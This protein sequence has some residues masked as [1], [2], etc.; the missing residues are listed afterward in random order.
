MLQDDMARTGRWLFRWRSY[1]PMAMLPLAAWDIWDLG[2]P[3]LCGWPRLVHE[4]SCVAV[5]LAGLAIRALTVGYA[6]T[7]TSERATGVVRAK[8]LNT[9]GPYSVVRNPLYLGNLLLFIGSILIA[10]SWRLTLVTALAFLI[11][12][13]RIIAAEEEVLARTFGDIYRDWAAKTPALLPRGA[14]WIPPAGRFRWGKALREFYAVFGAASVMFV[15]KTYSG[16][17]L[18]VKRSGL[19]WLDAAQGLRIDPAWGL[20]FAATGL[21]FVIMRSLKKRAGLLRD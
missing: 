18:A 5:V 10:G 21:L 8:E 19:T 3:D 12:Y 1:L 6:P 14:V 9:S 16:L 15:L 20:A 17:V 7:G 4:L 11:Y 13:E 2:P